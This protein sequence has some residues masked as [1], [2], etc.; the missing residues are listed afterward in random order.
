VEFSY[1]LTGTGWAEALVSDGC[2]SAAI[3]A[4]Y[5]TDALGVLLEAVG[6]MLDGAGEARCSWEEEPGEYRWLF[7]RTGEGVRLRI[8][9]F[10]DMYPPQPDDQ[11]TL[12]FESRRSMREIAYAVADAAQA[13]LDELGEDEYLRLWVEHPFPTG[14]LTRVREQLM[15]G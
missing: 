8:L 2:A 10:S 7:E 5:L 9:T 4:S 3:T 13:L 12:V 14:H 6:S 15:T 11:G 1:R